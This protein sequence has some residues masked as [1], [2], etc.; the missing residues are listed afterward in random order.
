MK[1][2]QNLYACGICQESYSAASDLVN[3]VESK[4]DQAK[5]CSTSSLNSL[6]LGSAKFTSINQKA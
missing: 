1:L 4:H 2:L 3:H 6:A 5:G